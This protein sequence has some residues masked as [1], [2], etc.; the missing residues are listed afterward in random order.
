MHSIYHSFYLGLS[1]PPTLDGPFYVANSIDS[2]STTELL[3]Y[4]APEPLS[5]SWLN[6][7]LVRYDEAFAQGTSYYSSFLVL[8]LAY[9]SSSLLP[10]N[11]NMN[12]FS[13]N[14]WSD[15]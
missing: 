14:S 6:L 5:P 4:S 13:P 10:D 1:L 2:N 12:L 3:P 8:H 11:Y 7:P 15:P 9:I